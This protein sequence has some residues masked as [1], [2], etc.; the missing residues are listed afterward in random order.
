MSFFNNYVALVVDARGRDANVLVKATN[1][2]K[3]I[4]QLENVGCEVIENQ[5]SEY[6]PEELVTTEM[7]EGLGIITLEDLLQSTDF[8]P[9]L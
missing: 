8:L 5:T 2:G 7:Y 4:E 6:D 3:A 9:H 1:W